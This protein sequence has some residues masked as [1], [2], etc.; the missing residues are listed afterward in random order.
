M[1]DTFDDLLTEDDIEFL[2]SV[3]PYGE[4]YNGKY[5][6]HKPTA[7]DLENFLKLQ[8]FENSLMIGLEDLDDDELK[9]IASLGW[10]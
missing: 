9:E 7:K 4:S 8:A 1:N 2:G 6:H 10:D 3:S 5:K